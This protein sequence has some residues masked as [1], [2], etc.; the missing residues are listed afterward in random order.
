MH[1]GG[2]WGGVRRW[3][4]GEASHVE[5]WRERGGPTGVSGHEMAKGRSG[6]RVER[7]S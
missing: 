2:E 6:S 5:D 4:T 1:D 3:G 7:V